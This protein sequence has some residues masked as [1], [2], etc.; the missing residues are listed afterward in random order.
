MTLQV[1]RHRRVHSDNLDTQQD[2]TGP[3][4]SL[5]FIFTISNV[6]VE[7]SSG[8]SDSIMKIAVE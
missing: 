7:S 8:D 3:V 2:E 4:R 5:Y 6:L 1:V